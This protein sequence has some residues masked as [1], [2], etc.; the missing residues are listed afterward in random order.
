MTKHFNNLLFDDLIHLN[1]NVNSLN[2]KCVQLQT[3]VND[4]K[5]I[6]CVKNVYYCKLLDCQDIILYIKDF[7]D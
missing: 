1:Q 7:I 5:V 3:C 4:K 2:M 6:L